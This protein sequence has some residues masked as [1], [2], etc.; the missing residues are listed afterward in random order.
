MTKNSATLALPLDLPLE[1]PAA[2]TAAQPVNESGAKDPSTMPSALTPVMQQYWNLKKANPDCLLFF[3]MGDFYE[4]F[5]DDAVTAAPVLDIALTSRNKDAD[6]E[7][8]MAGVPV[9][10]YEAY[11]P[12]LIK[13]GFRV[14]VAEQMEDPA[15]AKKRAGSKAVVDRQVVRILTPGTLTEDTF[16][17][18]NASNYLAVL[19]EQAGHFALSWCD[20]SAGQPMLQSAEIDGLSALLARVNPAELVIS[21]RLLGRAELNEILRPFKE[22]LT[23]LPQARFEPENAV[24]TATRYYNVA[25]LDSFG[26]FAR[27]ETTALGVLIDYIALTQK[28]QTLLL[29]RPQLA[30]ANG[31]LAIDAATRRNLELAQTLQGSRKGSLL[32]VIDRTQ[33]HAGA[34]LLGEM[35]AAPLCD[36]AVIAERADRVAF[37]A[38]EMELRKQ[39]RASLKNSPDMPRALTRL[40]LKRGGPRDVQIVRAGL[41]TA[42][43]TGT[44]LDRMAGGKL[45]TALLTLRRELGE[46]S[47]LIEKLKNALRDDLPVQARDGGF[48]AAGFSPQ[49]DEL[50]ALRDDGKK[51]IAALQAKYLQATKIPTLKIRYNQVIGYH[52]EVSPAQADKLMQPPFNAE[53][54]HRQSLVSAVRFTTTELAELERKVS[55]SAE[56]ALALEMQIFDQLVEEVMQ[57]FTVIRGAAE[58]LAAFD[59]AASLADLAIEQKW[60]RPVVDDS[61]AFKIDAA[62][63]PVV[64]AALAADGGTPFMPNSCNLSPGQRLWLITGPNMAG[65]STFLRQNAIIAI[66]AQIG[67]F[68]PAQAA[69]IG[70][71]DKLFSRVGAA[72]DLASGRST[73][74]VEMIETAAI[75]NQATPRSFVIL[76]EIGRGTA[77]FDGL[78]IAWG[79]LEYLYH[80][81]SCRGLFATHYHELTQLQDQLPDLRTAHA[82]VKEWEGKIIFLH[83]IAPGSADRSYGIHVAELA[84]LPAGVIARARVLLQELEKKQDGGITVAPVNPAQLAQMPAAKYSDAEKALAK[85]DPD[86]LSPREAL[87]A[88]YR[89]KQLAKG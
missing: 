4:L 87:D 17:E 88:L 45:G 63:H 10:A 18:S 72:D 82:K 51:L 60:V 40:A 52:I 85:L 75:L 70:V 57:R 3:R 77:T 64:E 1:M 54:I 43:A 81:N 38:G 36:V 58:A 2:P 5:Y 8:P 14:A 19:A 67:A 16:L 7:V 6:D 66:L 24:L 47:G 33:T 50:V 71:V 46:H 73:F 30:A 23:P 49:L 28:Q 42:M 22:S 68:V 39:L 69:H 84:G 21:D 25:S 12:K 59:V 89:L 79:S 15:A 44:L 13:A 9:H 29:T 65:K 41:E 83:E 48:V 20:L 80:H 78:S 27:T 32:G 34:R 11:I 61:F 35:L 31:L 74:M 86:Q 62:R 37:F 55:E 56:R 53:F 26:N 76:D